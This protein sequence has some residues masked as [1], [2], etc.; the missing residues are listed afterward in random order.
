M[1]RAVLSCVLAVLL[2]TVA[3]AARAAE[4]VV[5]VE[6]P[7]G[8]SKTIR[9]RSLPTGTVVAVRIV[10]SGRLLVALVGG[11]QPGSASGRPRSVFRGVV[12][13]RLSF[14]VAIPETGDYYLVLNNR[15]GSEALQVEAEIRAERARPK[16]AAPAYSP[17]PEKAS[18]S[19]R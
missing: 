12:E 18:W 8:E 14:K 19:P 11:R 3:S 13:R 9:L 6:L 17:R 16:P 1:P 7:A 15:P 2:G 5:S 4:A 10:S